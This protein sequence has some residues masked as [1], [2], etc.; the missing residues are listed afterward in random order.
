MSILSGRQPDITPA[1]LISAVPVIAGLAAGVGAWE[2]TAEQSRLVRGAILWS[3]AL[4]AADAF[5]RVGRGAAA[6]PPAV[7][8]APADLLGHPDAAASGSLGPPVEPGDEELVIDAAT[9]PYS[10]E[11]LEPVP[12]GEDF[13][14]LADVEIDP[15]LTKTGE[16][17]LNASKPVD[18]RAEQES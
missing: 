11:D 9:E 10:E 1:Q 8:P 5:L 15:D 14:S 13:A 18:F 3:A 17:A 12:G 16:A 7:A 6:R 2:P 4:V